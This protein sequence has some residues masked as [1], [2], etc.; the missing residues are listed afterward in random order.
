MKIFLLLLV[1]L[2]FS[3]MM[4]NSCTKENEVDLMG[5]R[6]FCVDSLVS[7]ENNIKPILQNNCYECHST[8]VAQ[9]GI[10]LDTYAGVTDAINNGYVLPQINRVDGAAQMPFGRAKLSDCIIFTIEKW[11]EEG[12]PNN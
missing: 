11:V 3:G 5:D 2:T 1:T 4:L 12:M 9:N 8:A 7:Y 6:I 10:I